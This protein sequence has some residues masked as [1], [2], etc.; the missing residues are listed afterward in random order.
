ME[1]EDL[2]LSDWY[3]ALAVVPQQPRLFEA[4]VADNIRF[5]RDLDADRV[6]QAARRAHIHDE[7]HTWSEGYQTVLRGSGSGVSGGQAQRLCIARALADD[8]QLLVLDE[9]TSALDVHSEGLIN[10][11]WLSSKGRSPWSSLPIGCRRCVSVTVSRARRGTGAGLRH[12]R[13]S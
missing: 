11:P 13:A 8:P 4:T 5:F 10:E 7:I 3:R 12:P 6:E 9:P 2:S 1:A